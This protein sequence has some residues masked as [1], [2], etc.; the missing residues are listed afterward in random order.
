MSRMMPLRSHLHPQ[1][2]FT[3]FCL[4]LSLLSLTGLDPAVAQEQKLRILTVSGRGVVMVPTT[5]T[6]VR[7]GVEIQGKTAQEVQQEVARR[8]SS[9]VA[10]LRSRQ[11]EKLQTAGISL[12]PTYNTHDNVQT[13]TGYAG[14][15]TVSFRLNTQEAGTLL[16]DAVKAGATRID[17]IGFIASDRDLAI[18]QQQALREATQEAQKQ[19]ETVLSALNLTRREITGIQINS[20]SASMPRPMLRSNAALYESAATTPVEGGEQQVEASVTL[21]ISY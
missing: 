20:T 5:Q 1:S 10:L 18:A 12:N 17:G 4:T 14:T 16:D 15:N 3:A 13:L 2:L 11:V 8:S 19:A 9:V 21:E 6:Q 7:L